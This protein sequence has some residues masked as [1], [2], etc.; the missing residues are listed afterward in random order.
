MHY[1][2]CKQFH[3]GEPLFRIVNT[4]VVWVLASVPAAEIGKIASPRRAVFRVTGMPDRFEIDERN[5]RLI[6]VGNVVDERTRSIPV[7]FE[8][9]NPKGR[10]RIGLFAE[11][12]IKTGI[13]SPVLAVPE[14]ALLEEEGKYS[15]YVHVEGEAFARREVEVGGREGDWVEVRNGL[16]ANDR[17]V[18]VGAYQ[19]RLASLSSQLP[20]HG[21]EH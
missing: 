14:S 2:L 8:V 3:P 16:A 9:A 13:Q 6:S 18:T 19:I 12:S 5:G 1:V 4:S 20:A 7:I 17:V 15:V 21:H 11:V 10:L